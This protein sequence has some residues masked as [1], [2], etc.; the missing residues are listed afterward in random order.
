MNKLVEVLTTPLVAFPLI[1]TGMNTII[2]Q[3]AGKKIGKIWGATTA[4]WLISAA[5]YVL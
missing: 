3:I 1:H 2:Y 4:I 5:I